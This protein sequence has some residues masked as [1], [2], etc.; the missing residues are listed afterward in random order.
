[1]KVTNT[2]NLPEPLVRAVT[3]SNRDREGCD[4]TVTELLKPPLILA[5]ERKHEAERE[6]D[7][8]DRIWALMGSAAHEVLRRSAKSGIV[9]ERTI[10]DVSYQGR[11]YRIGGQSDY[12]VTDQIL[13]DYKITSVWAVADGPKEEWEAQ[14]NIYRWMMAQYGVRLWSLCIVA[15]LRD[16]SKREAARNEDYPQA[17][18]K[19][20]D[21]P[22]WSD[23]QCLNWI[24]QRI[25]AH[26]AA[27]G[28]LPPSCSPS[29]R[30]ER[31][32]KFAV[33][34][35]DR[36]RAVKLHE[37]KE[38]AEE[39]CCKVPKGYVE[40]RP[41][42]Q[43]RCLHYCAVSDFCPWWKKMKGAQP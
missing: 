13:W 7:A 33:M 17:Q 43:V 39:H 20:F 16:W 34:V 25:G 42:E 5:L 29:E 36:K 40:V 12:C 1:M 38:A 6:E 24:T 22:M 2:S 15:L 4:Y 11:N 41:A 21:L 3:F 23:Q 19:V 14:L 8:T 18:A 28:T 9:E 32:A 37:T 27:K 35:K 26:E 31:P 10:V 30:W